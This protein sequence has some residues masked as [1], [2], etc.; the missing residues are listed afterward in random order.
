MENINFQNENG[1]SPLI[2][3]CI[4]GDYEQVKKLIKNGAN[5]HIKPLFIYIDKLEIAKLLIEL[6]ASLDEIV[7][8]KNLLHYTRSLELIKL[9]I[10]NGVDINYQDDYGFT[11][12]M[13][14]NYEEAELL[15]SYGADLNIQ[16]KYGDTALLHA[17]YKNDTELIKLLLKYH[18]DPYIKNNYDQDYFTYVNKYPHPDTIVKVNEYIFK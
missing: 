17:A 1:N 16:N 14:A 3:A 2:L 7:D 5:I 9:Y 4:K 13:N 11:I 18:A 8:G 12:L 10:I 15:I 6:G